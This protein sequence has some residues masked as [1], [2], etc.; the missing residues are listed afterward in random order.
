LITRCFWIANVNPVFGIAVIYGGLLLGMAIFFVWMS[1]GSKIKSWRQEQQLRPHLRC[2]SI[3]NSAPML[4]DYLEPSYP[5]LLRKCFP[6][7][8]VSPGSFI[9][10]TPQT[11]EFRASCCWNMAKNLLEVIQS[12]EQRSRI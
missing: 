6:T 5:S 1:H 11:P 9:R 12:P 4:V 7:N 3:G 8:G 10:A 2:R